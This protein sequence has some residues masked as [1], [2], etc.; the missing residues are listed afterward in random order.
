[1]RVSLLIYAVLTFLMVT[2]LSL[3]LYLDISLHGHLLDWLLFWAWLIM[4]VAIIFLNFKKRWGKIYGAALI[5]VAILTM[6]P[7]MIPFLTI[8]TFAV[9]PDDKR[10]RISDDL[11]I[12]EHQRFVVGKP[13]IVAI[14]S[15]GFYEKIVSETFPDFEANGDYREFYDV[16]SIRLISEKDADTLKVEFKFDTGTVLMSM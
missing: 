8:L 11:E 15:Y 12:Q 16:K 6:L 7:M 9:T 13:T 14:K 4:T 5:V 3:Y 10:Y 1:M 2:D